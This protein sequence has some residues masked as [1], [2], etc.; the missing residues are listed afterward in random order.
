MTTYTTNTRH[1]RLRSAQVDRAA[2]VLLAGAVGDALGVPYEF[3]PRFTGDPQMIGGGLGPYEPGEY[4]DDTQMAVCVAEV[5]ATGVDLSSTQALDAIADRFLDWRHNGA[6]DIGSSTS[7]AMRG[8]QPGSGSAARMAANARQVYE[9]TGLGGGNGGL[10][11]TGVVALSALGDRDATAAAARAVCELTHAEPRAAESCILWCEAVRVAVIEGR[12]DLAGGL[13]LLPDE[14]R[15]FWAAR[16][17]EATGADPAAW[18]SNGY[19]VTA[20]QAAWAAITATIDADRTFDCDH[21]VVALFAAAHAGHDTD[22]VAAIAG[23]LLG[24]RW[25]ASAVPA[26]YRRLV[27]GWPGLDSSDLV[28]LAVLTARGGHPDDTGW[29]A[30]DDHSYH[31]WSWPMAV[32]HPYDE[33]VLLGTI[34][35]PDHGCDAVVTLCRRGRVRDPRIA[36]EDQVD[37]WLLDKDDPAKNPNLEFVFDDT[38]KVIKQLRDEGKTVFVHCVAAEQRTP[39]V[40]IAYAR[41]L[42]ASKTEARS[43]VRE[44]LPGARGRGHL[45]EVA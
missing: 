11:R 45:W 7:A 23:A 24:A 36:R 34:S 20:M 26:R 42:G 30:A 19:T 39:S 17:N 21:L 6:S 9:T 16:I 38:A 4:S 13:D 2:G 22:T 40:A 15:D 44:T 18:R 3:A 25:G 41:L 1:P 12:F 35:T 8:I 14:S 43:A 5:A 28:R 10:M 29:P 37:V 27:H 31:G 32:P 33:G